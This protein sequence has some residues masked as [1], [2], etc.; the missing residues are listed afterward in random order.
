MPC[1]VVASHKNKH[2]PDDPAILGQTR[3][4]LPDAQRLLADKPSP[5]AFYDQMLARHPRRGSSAAG[6]VLV[7]VWSPI[8]S[9]LV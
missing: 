1:A 2:L 9:T 5:R 7:R 6:P 3:D 8:T 4:Y